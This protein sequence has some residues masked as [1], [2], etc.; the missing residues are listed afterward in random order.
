MNYEIKIP[1]LNLDFTVPPSKSVVHRELIIKFLLSS[2]EPEGPQATDND[3]IRATRACLKA[4]YDA[5][6]DD[7]SSDVVMPC[8]ESGSTL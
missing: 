1:S 5:V 2:L 7:A 4:L 8:N 6:G 3:D